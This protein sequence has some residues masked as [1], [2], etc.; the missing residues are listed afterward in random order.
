MELS[1]LTGIRFYAA[2]GLYLC[3]VHLVPGAETF[4]SQRLLFNLGDAGV[5][6]CFVLSGFILRYN[7]A[8]KSR[9]SVSPTAY[10]GLRLGPTDQD[11]SRSSLDVAARPAHSN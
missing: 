10:V 9:V 4:T 1:C 7:Y 8:D 11:L 6:F 5:S 2:L 3:H